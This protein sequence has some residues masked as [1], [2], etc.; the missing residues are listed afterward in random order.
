MDL[1]RRMFYEARLC[2]VVPYRIVPGFRINN[3]PRQYTTHIY[4]SVWLPSCCC[5]AIRKGGETDLVGISY[6]HKTTIKKSPLGNEFLVG[7]LIPFFDSI[8]G[9]R[10]KKEERPG[11]IHLIILC[12]VCVWNFSSQ[13]ELYRDGPKLFRLLL[14]IYIYTLG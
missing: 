10:E 9:K 8:A 14:Y 1:H 13:E 5:R 6:I 4:T 3:M 11:F 7:K 2:S 12:C